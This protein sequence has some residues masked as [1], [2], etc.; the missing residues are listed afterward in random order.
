ML[1]IRHVGDIESN[2]SLS[3][4][5]EEG[6]MVS[7]I[8]PSGERHRFSIKEGQLVHTESHTHNERLGAIPVVTRQ[9]G[10]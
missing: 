9:A 5:C 7:V 1:S 2:I 8:E 6:T 3:T 10:R 4:I